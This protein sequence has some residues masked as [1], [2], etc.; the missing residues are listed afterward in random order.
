MHTN[1]THI[2]YPIHISLFIYMHVQQYIGPSFQKF[3]QEK[4]AQTLGDLNF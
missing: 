2:A 1:N 3:N 4:W